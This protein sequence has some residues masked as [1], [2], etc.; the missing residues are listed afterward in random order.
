MPTEPVPIGHAAHASE[1]LSRSAP[2]TPRAWLYEWCFRDILEAFGWPEARVEAF[3]QGHGSSLADPSRLFYAFS[4]M[5]HVAAELL[6]DE[7]SDLRRFRNEKL[8][9][10]HTLS[11]GLEDAMDWSRTQREGRPPRAD[12]RQ[13][14]GEVRATVEARGGRFRTVASTRA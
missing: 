14:L 11:R 13:A 7:F 3:V 4:P 1:S 2:R 5:S 12:W 6:E 8:R 9:V 10:I